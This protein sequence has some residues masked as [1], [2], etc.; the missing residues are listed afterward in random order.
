MWSLVFQQGAAEFLRA[1]RGTTLRRLRDFLES[2]CDHPF[3][4]ADALCR[5]ASG[6]M[7]EIRHSTDFAITYWV[8]VVE[9]EIRIVEIVRNM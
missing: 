7:H 3:K 1:Q 5:G 6:R 8:D 9:K 2:I 4:P